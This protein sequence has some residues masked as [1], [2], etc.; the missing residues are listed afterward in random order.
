MIRSTRGAM[1]TVVGKDTVSR[2]QIE[3]EVVYISHIA[4]IIRKGMNPIIL[5]EAN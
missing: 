5:P 3:D 1:F 2:V 4:N